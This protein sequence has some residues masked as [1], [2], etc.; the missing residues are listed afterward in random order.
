[1]VLDK[2]GKLCYGKVKVT[3]G[4]KEAIFN[5]RALKPDK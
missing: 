5:D 3:F 4:K 1:M 2:K